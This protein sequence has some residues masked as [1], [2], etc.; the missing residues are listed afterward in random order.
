MP[1]HLRL[2][3]LF[4]ALLA[5]G[6][7]ALSAKDFDLATASIQDINAAIDA[8][9]L[10]SEKLVQLYLNRIAAYDQAGPKLNTIITLNPKA[11]ELARAL[12]EER[13]TKGRR[14]PLH[15]IPVVVKDLINTSDLPTTGGF[16]A[17][18]GAVPQYDANVIKRLRDAGAI[19]L[20]KTNMSDWLG[21]SR[22]DGGSSLAGLV[23]N[24]YDL[25][26]GF[27]GS[28][29]G[30][31]SGISSYLATVGLGSETGTS[32]RGP[33][34][35][36]SL[37]GLAGT[38]GL[39]GRSGAMANS[40]THERIGPIARNMYDLAVTLDSLVG[41]DAND[42]ITAKSLPYLPYKSY[43]TFLNPDGLRGARIGV[44]RD[45]F[46]SGPEHQEGLALADQAIF[47]L[48]K[49]GADVYDPVTLGLN[50]ERIRMIKVNYWEEET[51]LDKYL[52]DFGPNAPF[53][54]I[55]EM[56]AKFPDLVKPD[57]ISFG[58][59][60]PGTDP[61][62]RSRLKARQTLREAVVALMDKYALDAV[63][64]PFKTI[65]AAKLS[66][67]GGG[68]TNPLNKIAR[69]G[70]A[71]IDS[72]NYLSSMTGLPGL[73]VPMGYV[74]N[75][76]PLSFEFLGR[77]FAEPTLLRLVSGYEAQTHHRKPPPFVPALPG[78]KFSY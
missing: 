68:D 37:F 34:T 30:T 11:L 75:G 61:E 32:I 58:S 12:D 26:R 41:I 77:P 15:G 18:K 60:T 62:Y 72:D 40:F 59:Y 67:R 21:K 64:F 69:G 20:A 49:A 76:I 74:A 8:G 7:P 70:D 52:R 25:S 63:V 13:K 31:G 14:S 33:T 38:E 2:A 45:M 57:F 9:A 24:P 1:R 22:P 4:T 78:E 29:S 48:R 65:P 36:G 66:A 35:D 5:L 42:L 3:C 27:A 56:V 6:Q 47:A 71:V 54:S 17:M 50:L 23:L 44:L 46:R 10:S 28:S 53:H 73:L 51:V 19:I 43:T 39:V 55:K 16:I